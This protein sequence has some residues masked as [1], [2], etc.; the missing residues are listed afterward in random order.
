V[1]FACI[2]VTGK[3][4]SDS[5]HAAEVGNVVAICDINESALDRKARALPNAGSS[6]TSA[7]C[8]TRW[9]GF[10]TPSPSASPTTNHAVASMMGIKNKKA[11]YCQNHVPLHRRRPRAVRPGGG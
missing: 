6:P 1:N 10:E 4:D 5:S 3:G 7:S 9:Q 8:S 2:G 11:V